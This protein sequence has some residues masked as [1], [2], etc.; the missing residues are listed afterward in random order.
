M[1][2]VNAVLTPHPANLKND[3][4]IPA[5]KVREL[6]LDFE[7]SFAP[8]PFRT[9]LNQLKIKIDSIQDVNEHIHQLTNE[10]IAEAHENDRSEVY[11]K[12]EYTSEMNSV[13][14]PPNLP[15]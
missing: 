9:P 2:K 11:I 4:S 7:P 5:L 13:A 3:K 14:S 6:S 12:P 1:D 15:P 8:H 10:S